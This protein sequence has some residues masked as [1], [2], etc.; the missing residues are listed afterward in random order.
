MSASLLALL[1]YAT[2]TLLLLAGIAALRVAKTLSGARRANQFAP[3]G[4]DVSPFSGRLCRAHAN[5]YENLPIVAAIILVAA[6]TGH[7]AIT[8]PLA[9]WLVAA[10]LAQSLVHLAS[11]RSRMVMLRFAFML[12]QVLILICWLAQLLP[13]ALASAGVA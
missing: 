6:S 9:L 7:G 1:L 13:L 8:D 2:W 3:S 12:A 10:R 5:C 4:E 11:T